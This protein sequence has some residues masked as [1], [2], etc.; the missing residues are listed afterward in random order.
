MQALRALLRDR[1]GSPSVEFAMSLPALV[2]MTVGVMQLG[3]VFLANA[4]LRN[5]VETAARYAVVYT[6]QTNTTACGT[7][8]R[9]GYPTNDQIRAK[10]T[11]NTFGMQVSQLAT[12]VVTLGTSNGECY[13]EVTGTYPVRFNFIFFTTPAFNLTYTR[14]AFQL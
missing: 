10:V 8:N 7:L 12:P 9:N 14:R 2:V 13:V 11:S 4:G 5:A 3:I 6:G 1:S